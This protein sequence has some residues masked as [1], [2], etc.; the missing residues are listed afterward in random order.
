VKTL[1][2]KLVDEA[3]RRANRQGLLKSETAAFT[4]EAPRDPAHGEAACNA[5]LVL[6]RL[7]SKP[8]RAI[9]EIIVEQIERGPELADVAIAGAGFINFRMAREYWLQE[10]RE[11]ARSDGGFWRPGLSAGGRVQVEFLSANPTGPLTVGHGRNAVLGDTLSRLLETVGYQVT[12]EYYFNNG[13]RQMKL[14]SESVR[15]RYLQELGREASLP[16][17]G[18]QGQY[19][20]EIAASLVR[21]YRDGLLSAG[22]GEVFR[23]EAERA[24][25]AD[26]LG[27][28]KRLGIS[29]DVFSNENDLVSK[30]FVD[31]VIEA[32]NARAH[33]GSAAKKSVCRISRT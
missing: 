6:A 7:E 27:T 18:Y 21:Q 1:L 2:I 11:I 29:F 12:R 30:G 5:A 25:F 17:E 20:K 33:Y 22:D 23:A 26:I 13:G 4:I 10:L 31:A 16:D 19:I 14:L 15:A 24:I 9:A 32:S 3:I 8:P 28:C